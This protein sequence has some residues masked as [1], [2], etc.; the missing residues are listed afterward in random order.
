LNSANNKNTDGMDELLD[1]FFQKLDF[2]DDSIVN[3]H[4]D[5]DRECKIGFA[6]MIEKNHMHKQRKLSNKM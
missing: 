1:C 5:Y 4:L 2:V 6:D 3:E